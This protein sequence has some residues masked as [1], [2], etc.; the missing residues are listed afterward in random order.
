MVDKEIKKWVDF[1]K[2][3][4][5]DA[6]I[7]VDPYE[8]CYQLGLDVI[9]RDIENDGYLICSDGCKLVIISSRVGNSHKQR[10]IAAHELG[11]FL[12]HGDSMYCCKNLNDA[13]IEKLNTFDQEYQA[14]QFA[15]ELLLAEDDL[16]KYLPDKEIKF[17]DVSRIADYFNVSMTMCARKAV[18]LSKTKGEMLLFYYGD[19]LKWFTRGDGIKTMP[20]RLQENAYRFSDLKEY[21]GSIPQWK[22]GSSIPDEGIEMFA[23]YG[24]QRMVLIHNAS[25]FL[26][27]N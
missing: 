12:L 11:H 5:S 24:N 22:M 18:S 26:D 8:I 4:D 10:F 3:Q 13:D 14:N 17:S 15:S 1:A 20:D 2:A 27:M 19:R 21:V 16:I 9:M 6:L 23:T 7:A 25:K